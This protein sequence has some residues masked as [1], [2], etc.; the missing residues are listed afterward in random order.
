[1]KV[2]PVPDDRSADLGRNEVRLSVE[3]RQRNARRIERLVPAEFLVV[4]REIGGKT[5]LDDFPRAA[6]FPGI[7]DV[8]RVAR[9][10]LDR[11]LRLIGLAVDTRAGDVDAAAVLLVEFVDQPVGVEFRGRPCGAVEILD[12]DGGRQGRRNAD[13]GCGRSGADQRGRAQEIDDVSGRSGD[14]AS[15][16]SSLFHLTTAIRRGTLSLQRFRRSR[17][18]PTS[19]PLASDNFVDRTG[20]IN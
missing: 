14:L 15:F 4:V 5:G 10:D 2:L 17:P 3:L 9:A 1:M 12:F 8:G 18:L 11:L 20:P 19:I 13:C 6:S 16:I 7:E